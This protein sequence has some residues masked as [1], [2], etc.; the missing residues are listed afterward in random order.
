MFSAIPRGIIY[1]DVWFDVRNLVRSLRTYPPPDTV[2]RFEEAFARYMDMPH[3]IAFPFARSAVYAALSARN[4][5]AGSEIIMPPITIKPMMDVVLQ[6]GLK[7]VFVDIDPSDL[8][9]DLAAFERVVSDKTKAV[10][11]TYLFGIVP[12]VQALMDTARKHGLFVIEDFS[13]NFNAEFGGRKLGTFGDMGVYS[14]SSTKTFDIYGGG[15]AVTRSPELAAELRRFQQKLR[16]PP[17]NI[18]RDKIY[19]NVLRN[20]FSTRLVFS[21]VTLPMFKVLARMNPTVMRKL[22]GARLGLKPTLEMPE[23]WLYAFTPFQAEVGLQLLEGVQAFDEKRIKNVEALK[24]L[25]KD[26]VAFRYPETRADA[27]HVFWQF[28]AYVDDPAELLRH[29]YRRNIDTGTT[30]LSLISDMDIYEDRGDTPNA[31]RVHKT[32]VFVP[33]Y[34]SLNEAD[35]K[36]VA[37]GF[38]TYFQERGRQ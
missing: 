31:A 20:L 15:L 2:S 11:L 9:F 19:L 25:L 23:E 7:P 3:A 27:R 35:L 30:N 17:P 24:R 28:V 32:A 5:P 16:M 29:L 13:H 1:H 14:C 18:L 21:C 6:L 26:T 8:C 22:T 12:D 36:R 4:F 37:D 10:L 33:A 38:R 34:P